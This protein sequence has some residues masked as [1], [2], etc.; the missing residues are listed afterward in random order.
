MRANIFALVAAL[1]LG[2]CATYSE[3]VTASLYENVSYRKIA[4]EA[5]RVA[6]RATQAAGAQDG[7]AKAMH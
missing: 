5:T 6:N 2:G 7:Q 1:G 4:E 3:E